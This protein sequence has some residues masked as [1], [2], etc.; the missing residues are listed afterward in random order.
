ML[1]DAHPLQDEFGCVKVILQVAVVCHAVEVRH[2]N[3]SLLDS[4]LPTLD[5]GSSI[6]SVVMDCVGVFVTRINN[7][8]FIN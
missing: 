3:Q 4:P 7:V 1:A 6:L 5:F 8:V 2:Q